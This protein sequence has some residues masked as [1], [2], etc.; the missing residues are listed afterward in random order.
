MDLRASL[1]SG[2]MDDGW[3]GHWTIGAGY[4]VALWGEE[5]EV[6]F[7]RSVWHIRTATWK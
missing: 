5:E 6:N 7:R 4:V 2:E 3:T 1:D